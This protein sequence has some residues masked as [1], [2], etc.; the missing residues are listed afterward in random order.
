MKAAQINNYGDASQIKIQEVAIP[1]IDDTQVRIRVHAAS[2]NPFD[3]TIRSGA[4]KDAIPLELPAT[5]GG[6]IAGIVEEIGANVT[7]LAPGDRVYGSANVVAGASGA[8]AEYTATASTQVSLAPEGL[9]FTEAAALPLVGASALQ[10]LLTHLELQPNQKIFI[11]GGAGGIGTIAIQVAKDIGAHVAT[12]A[13][14]QGIELVSKLGADEVIDYKLEDF[15]SALSDYDAVFDTVGGEDFRKCLTVLR[16]GGT[17]VSMI[18]PPD[19]RYAT[20]LGVNAMMQN[21]HITS[22]ILDELRRYVE[23]GAVKPLVASV[24]PLEQVSAA[25]TARESG[26][27]PG[28]IVLTLT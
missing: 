23:K 22:E 20:E 26:T 11:H 12:T 27:T 25:F 19:E 9:D 28:K 14:G 1:A 15:S 3:T 13:T 16:E 17:A 8:F 10:A 5:L 18:A 6:D 21:T 2:L 7:S 24:Y 4:M